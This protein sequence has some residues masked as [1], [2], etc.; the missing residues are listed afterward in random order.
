M[1]AGDWYDVAR[2][3]PTAGIDVFE[4]YAVQVLRPWNNEIGNPALNNIRDKWQDHNDF[5]I[6]N[7]IRNTRCNKITDIIKESDRP[8]IQNVENGT[9]MNY[10]PLHLFEENIIR[11][12]GLLSAKETSCTNFSID[13]LNVDNSILYN[14]VFNGGRE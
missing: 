10:N 4:N 1:E 13:F 9:S 12:Y 2:W 6:N 14:E 3:K 11:R 8:I 5:I 7:D